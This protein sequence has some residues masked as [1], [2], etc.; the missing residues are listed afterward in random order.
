MA[1]KTVTVR[2]VTLGTGLPK[3][4]ISVTAEDEEGVRTQAEAIRG[5]R[6]AGLCEWRMDCLKTVKDE[7]GKLDEAVILCMLKT[8]RDVLG[9]MPLIATFRSVADGGQT[10]LDDL[11]YEN[12]LL[13][14]TQS[15]YADI[16][17]VEINRGESLVMRLVKSIHSY[18]KTV[19]MS[20][21]DFESTPEAG[22]MAEKLRAMERL[23][24]DICKLACMS[25][26]YCD[27]ARLI[28]ATA[29][30]KKTVS[31]PIITMAMGDTGRLSRVCGE[32]SGSC[33]S[34]GMLGEASAPG[35]IKADELAGYIG[36]L[37]TLFG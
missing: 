16:V 15:G 8:L 35:Q 28:Y 7:N 2:N 19:L 3:I 6:S 10:E 21:H 37:H 11:L 25:A 17:D 36:E 5:C 23:G 31:A 14:V 13:M 4:C 20:F 27:A 30:A 32:F 34:F 12:L 26:D 18:D 22:I 1:Y 24:A 29:L 33:L 9:D